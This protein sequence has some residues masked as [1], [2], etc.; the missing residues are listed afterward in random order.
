MIAAFFARDCGANRNAAEERHRIR[1]IGSSAIK[2]LKEKKLSVDRSDCANVVA[3][4]SAKLFPLENEI[5][6][7]QSSFDCVRRTG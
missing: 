4:L 2:Y 6:L 3:K 5:H 7:P 1:L